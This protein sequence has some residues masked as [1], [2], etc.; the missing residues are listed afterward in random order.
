MTINW[1]KD[2]DC[3]PFTPALRSGRMC[4][5]MPVLHDLL[6]QLCRQRHRHP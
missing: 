1:K 3:D 5:R 6:L 4:H 2:P